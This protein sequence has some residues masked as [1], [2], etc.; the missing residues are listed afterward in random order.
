M[1]LPLLTYFLFLT[2]ILIGLLWVVF[3]GSRA[4]RKGKL[5]SW[6]RMYPLIA[7]YALF[8]VIA[9]IVMPFLPIEEIEMREHTTDQEME[10]RFN[11]PFEEISDDY[12]KEWTF[13]Y[14]GGPLM[15][16]AEQP[17]Q[18]NAQV[19]VERKE[20]NEQIIEVESRGVQ[21]KLGINFR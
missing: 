7:V 21:S 1:M 12:Q 14:S 16:T 10:S 2:I 13:D 19:L 3:L 8:L 15:L 18:I 9:A 6:K 11:Q 4:I 17:E 5:F 20:T